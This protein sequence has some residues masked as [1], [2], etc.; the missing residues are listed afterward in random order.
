[1]PVSHTRGDSSTRWLEWLGTQR[2]VLHLWLLANC[3]RA[4]PSSYKCTGTVGGMV[5]YDQMTTSAQNN[6]RLCLIINTPQ[7]QIDEKKGKY[8]VEY[9]LASAP[10]GP[11]PNGWGPT[12]KFRDP[13][14]KRSSLAS[15]FPLWLTA[16]TYMIGCGS[17]VYINKNEVKILSI[18]LSINMQDTPTT[19]SR[20]VLESISYAS[21]RKTS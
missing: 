13:R 3:V 14:R 19:D 15:D 4:P 9:L 10:D 12:L 16:S 5:V 2:N 7:V 18:E 21:A 11:C 1:M 20:G 8:G 17:F 6:W